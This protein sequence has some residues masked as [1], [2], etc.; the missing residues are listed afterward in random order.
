M[1]YNF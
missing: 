1:A